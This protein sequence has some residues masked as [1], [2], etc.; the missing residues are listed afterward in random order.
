M[1]KISWPIK[2]LMTI[3]GMAI[4]RW[5]AKANPAIIIALAAAT[6]NC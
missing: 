3:M 2:W 6:S 4:H 5:K 1:L